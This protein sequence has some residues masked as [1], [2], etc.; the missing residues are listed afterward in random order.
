MTA[1]TVHPLAP[2][3]L[4]VALTIGQVHLTVKDHRTGP[5]PSGLVSHLAIGS[6][7]RAV[8]DWRC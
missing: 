1:E 3:V 6:M 4:R 7:D 5:V 2:A 8:M